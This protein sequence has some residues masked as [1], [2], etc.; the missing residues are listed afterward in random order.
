MLFKEGDKLLR[1]HEQIMWI[2]TIFMQL[3]HIYILQ[4]QIHPE[5]DGAEQ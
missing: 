2:S 4:N 1:M 3:Y 5:L